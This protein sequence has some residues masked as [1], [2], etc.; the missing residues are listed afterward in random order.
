M[1][2]GSTDKFDFTDIEGRKKMGRN[3]EDGG[4][5]MSGAS[6]FLM[7]LLAIA[8]AV[9]VGL[10][11][12]FAGNQK[13]LNCNCQC[14]PAEGVVTMAPGFLTETCKAKAVLGN[15]EL[16]GL[17]PER[18]TTP[19]MSTTLGMRTAST[20]PNTTMPPTSSPHPITD[21]RLP[22]S[23]KPLHY[24]LNLRP[25]M[26]NDKPETFTFNGTVAIKVECK[27]PTDNIT[28]H[29]ATQNLTTTPTVEAS[30][31]TEVSPVVLHTT[32]DVT[33]QFLIM[34]LD[35][36][37]VVGN[38][39]V[40]QLAFEDRLSNTVLLG[41]YVSTYRDEAANMTKY[42]TATQFEP[43]Y[44]RHAFPC[45]DEPAFK[46]TFDI[47]LERQPHIISLSNM[48]LVS[49]V[50]MGDGY[51]ADHFDVSV[52]MSTYLVAFVFGEL[53]SVKNVTENNVLF[54]VYTTPQNINQTAF[55]LNLG[56]RLLD[57]F[58]EYF[59]IS[60]ALPKLDNVGLPDFVYGA[61]ENWGL[62][63][64]REVFLLNVEG[65]TTTYDMEF[66]AEV[67][68][69]E[70]VHSWFG[71]LVSP[72]W[73]DDI[74]LNEGFATFLSFLGVDRVVPEWGMMDLVNLYIIQPVMDVDSV[75]SIVPIFREAYTP[76]QILA[77]FD[78]I[79]YYKGCGVI[80]MMWFFLGPET[81]R[82]GLE[83][84]LNEKAY[85]NGAHDDLWASLQTQAVNDG[86]TDFDIKSVMDS[87]ILQTNYPVVT[88]RKVN[89]GLYLN[90]SRFLLQSNNNTDFAGYSWTIPF[91]YTTD[92]KLNYDQ[93]ANNVL[94]MAPNTQVYA[95]D[96]SISKMNGWVIGNIQHY[97][98][99]RVN[100]E[101]EN[102]NALITQLKTDYTKIHV[103]N[104]GTLISD[105]WALFKAGQADLVTAW[106]MLTYLQ[107]ETEFIPWQYASSELVYPNNML[108]RRPAY[109]NFERFVLSLLEGRSL[110]V[111]LND[112]RPTQQRSLSKLIF[113]LSCRYG[114]PECATRA[115]Q[116]F[117]D[118]K[119]SGTLIPPDVKE[120]VFC[121]AI[122]EGGEEEWNY[123]Y[124]VYLNGPAVEQA[125]A[126][127]SLGCTSRAWIIS[128]YLDY[129]LDPSKI[130]KQDAP[131]AFTSL[132]RNTNAFYQTFEYILAK[133]EFIVVDYQLDVNALNTIVSTAAA[134]MFTEYE[135]KKI[136]NW[137]DEIHPDGAANLSGFDV[138][139][140]RISVNMEW[141]NK[142]YERVA[143]WLEN[144]VGSGP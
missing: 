18:T 109:G 124:D 48:P 31:N 67:L 4:C 142:Y 114:V 112:N 99:Y 90:Q 21:T 144:Y 91:T 137:R 132:L 6:G 32:R 141:H 27:S 53:E 89:G 138:A 8:I 64:Y 130:R 42:M 80:R 12:H 136:E 11:V 68:S 25:E 15:Q 133:W 76:D 45:F 75:E 143:Q 116:L 60:F 95:T 87:W 126:L 28:L 24:E 47:K 78:I 43:T 84:Y 1:F 52:T 86:K 7:V 103:V 55:A 10:I 79:T 122:K 50:T 82:K 41:M 51:V 98:Y 101:Q 131:R 13:E 81:F 3:D 69:H 65:V 63:T 5:R 46:A 106:D 44:A 38:Q 125:G 117:N 135:M 30:D 16:C 40:I 36:P 107:Y 119:N 9:G 71:N 94:W 85:G 134:G 72:A 129:I 77:L 34:T 96:A 104:R 123:M 88:V 73:W 14:G 58:E 62:M 105:L 83:R 2:E 92:Q 74:W 113:S 111:S 49:S 39:Y 26:Y 127:A 139:L 57:T 17:C 22:T 35:K 93:S 97:G 128:R 100:Y 37:L 110:N 121:R 19:S 54:G 20:M 118:W 59:N 102:W 120:S 61:M 56:S 29:I 108:T 115:K 140:N 23:V 70:I 33:R 66:S